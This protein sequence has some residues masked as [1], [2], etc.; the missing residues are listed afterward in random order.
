[1]VFNHLSL[2]FNVALSIVI[3]GM[4]GIVLA[5]LAT[6]IYRQFAID[7]QRSAME[8]VIGLQVNDKLEEMAR[9]LHDLGQALQ[10]EKGFRR[11]FQQRDRP[12]LERRLGSQFHQY[13]VTAGILRLER[14]AIYDPDF[15]IISDAA[16]EGLA[17]AA[18]CPN[19]RL[20]ASLRQGA[21]RLKTITE[22]C[23]VDNRAHF[24]V[25][26]PIGGLRVTGYLE[27]VADP[28][29]S[30]RGLEDDLGRPLR[31]QFADGAP[32]YQSEAWP[33]A[34]PRLEEEVARYRPL[35]ELGETAMHVAIAQDLRDFEQR[36]ARSRNFLI[37]AVALLTLL[38]A[39]SMLF[40]IN[41]TALQPLTTLGEQLRN[42]RRDKR[43]LGRQ[44]AIKGNAEVM[45]L[46][47]GFNEMTD[48]LRALYDTLL[49]RNQELKSEVNERQAAERELKSHRDH[50]E[51]LVKQ[52][53]LDLAQA[54]DAAL[55][56]NEIKSQ[57]LANMSHELRTPLNAVMG[58]SELLMS[59]ARER[60][61]SKLAD[62]LQRVYLAGEHLLSLINSILDLSKIEAGRMDMYEEWFSVSDLVNDVA[63]T[64]RPLVN[65]RNNT[66]AVQCNENTGILFADITKLRQILFNLLSNACKFTEEGEI[67]LDVWR[68][69][70][71]GGEQIFFAIKDTGI[72]M[73]PD[74]QDKVFE[75]FRQADASTT[76]RY[77]GTGLGL[78]I[79]QH[80]S[81][82][83]GGAIKVVSA[84]AE[85]STF[86]VMLPVR[87][88]HDETQEGKSRPQRGIVAL[89]QRLSKMRYDQQMERRKRVSTVLVI[90]D[91]P[92][93]LHIMSQYL[94]QK[95]FDVATAAGGAEGLS[96][97]KAIRPDVIT[98]D[99]VMPGM[100][101]WTVLRVL[102][103]D[104]ELC[105]IP[106]ILVTLVE[107]RS[108]GF[109]LGAE[110]YMSKPVD[111]TRLYDI[112]NRCVRELHDKQD[113]HAPG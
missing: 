60:G 93:T 70:A 38:L 48:E 80:F 64:I 29:F 35:T 76:R 94:I 33:E 61:E 18:S 105:H 10:G 53:T 78:A 16:A 36:L 58:Y 71:G 47:R 75:A 41:R 7:S 26:L 102:K 23:L 104:E 52:R 97:A 72:G 103:Q 24:A 57:F 92:A 34:G 4:L 62:D 98:L 11:D 108:M 22:L 40:I 86:T 5:V 83:M 14:L 107:N 39:T 113:E 46:A 106:V 12:A 54:R 17:Y 95:G 82:M 69:S 37:G 19:L 91:D 15:N 51:E 88:E 87:Q 43:Q 50:L 8:Q 90:D 100:D 2:R 67:R 66:L 63:E 73:Q 109:A 74:Q 3:M 85:G 45:S 59:N 44:L 65:K 99:V 20:R 1:M 9:M 111:K 81:H 13:F 110:D 68:E 79:S 6:G 28:I 27:V 96:L 25:L 55:E 56:A 31:I 84:P 101:G 112:I 77:G 30:F 49:A 21:E 42:I 89:G 32:A